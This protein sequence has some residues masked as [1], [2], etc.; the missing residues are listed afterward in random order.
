MRSPVALA[1]ILTSLLTTVPCA[2]QTP[3]FVG[4]R[5]DPVILVLGPDADAG[6]YLEPDGSGL[7]VYLANHGHAVWIVKVIVA[8]AN[9]TSLTHRLAP[10]EYTAGIQLYQALTM[11]FQDDDVVRVIYCHARVIIVIVVG[12]VGF[13]SCAVGML[14]KA[15]DIELLDTGILI[16]S[17]IDVPT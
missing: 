4:G 11:F 10:L 15:V 1:T 12:Q 7:A 16:I 14:V 5:G 3:D 8:A 6:L 13:A 17:H 2:A 9:N